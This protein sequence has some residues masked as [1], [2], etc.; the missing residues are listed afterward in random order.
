MVNTPS[1]YMGK[2]RTSF[3]WAAMVSPSSGP[4]MFR[5]LFPLVLSVMQSTRYVACNGKGKRF[6]DGERQ[7]SS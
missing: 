7:G 5:I 4:P 3:P 1:V 2:L 6:A